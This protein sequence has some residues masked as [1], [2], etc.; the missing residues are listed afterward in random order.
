[1]GAAQRQPCRARADSRPACR[2][3]IF[4]DDPWTAPLPKNDSEIVRQAVAIRYN[5]NVFVEI[6]TLAEMARICGEV[7]STLRP[8]GPFIVESSSTMAFGHTFRSYSYPASGELR[9]GDLTPCVVATPGG[10]FM[11]EDTYWTE[12]DYAS[13]LRGAGLAIAT[14]DYPLPRDPPA[15]LT[16]EATVPPCVVIMATKP[17]PAYR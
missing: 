9:S 7:A 16:D 15:W 5:L 4:L 8:A 1:M 17:H 6:R 2:V 10:Q 11:I 14:I 12:D 3:E 13:G